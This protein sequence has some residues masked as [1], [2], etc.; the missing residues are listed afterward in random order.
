MPKIDLTEVVL[1]KLNSILT[2]KNNE[3]RYHGNML[4]LTEIYRKLELGLQLK[5]FI[6]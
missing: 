4:N 1:D 2:E 6:M 3:V 5:C